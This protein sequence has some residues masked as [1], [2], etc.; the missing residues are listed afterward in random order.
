MRI[1]LGN[2]QLK[3]MR[4]LWRKQS[5]TAREITEELSKEGTFAHST[6]QTLLRKLEA[7]GAVSHEIQDR[8]FYFKPEVEES[9]VS[10]SA[11]SEFIDRMFEGSLSGLVAHVLDHEV[12]APEEFDRLEKMIKAKKQENSKC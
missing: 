11:T 1:R 10:Q 2:V 6:V 7:K 12:I 5:A 3:I 9:L 8:T 4:I